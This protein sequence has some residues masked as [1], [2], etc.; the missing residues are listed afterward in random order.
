MA[1]VAFIADNM[2]KCSSKSL[3]VMVSTNY[4]RRTRKKLLTAVG[5]AARHDVQG[6]VEMNIRKG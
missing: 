5:N 6:D 2:R 3:D 1:R 4:S